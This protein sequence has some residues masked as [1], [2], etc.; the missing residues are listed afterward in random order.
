VGDFAEGGAANAEIGEIVVPRSPV[1][2]AG[3]SAV[4]V[5]ILQR[6]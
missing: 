4:K 1:S 6:R 2:V 5:E 3:K